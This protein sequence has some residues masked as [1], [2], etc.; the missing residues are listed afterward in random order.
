MGGADLILST[1]THSPAISALFAG[2][3][4]R[5]KLL[6]ASSGRDPITIAPGRLVSGERVVEGTITG[7]PIESEKTLDFSVLADVR[8]KIEVMPLA[9]AKAAYQRMKQ[10]Q[11]DFRM[12]LRMSTD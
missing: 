8:P 10:G 3:A 11:A 9:Q 5:G 1:A 2:L 7:S 4:P 12:V 6:I